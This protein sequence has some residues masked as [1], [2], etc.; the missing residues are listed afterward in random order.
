MVS[1]LRS[2]LF[3]GPLI[4]LLTIGFGTAS[5]VA[6]L[7]DRSGRSPERLARAWARALLRVSGV[8]LRTEGF[9]KIDSRQNYVFVANHRSYMDIPALLASLPVEIRFYA[10]QGLFLIP[11]LGTHLKRAGH[12]PVVRGDARASVKSMTLGARL[13]QERHV[14]MLLFPEGGRSRGSMREFKEGAA[15]IAIKAGVPAVPLGIAGT[16]DVLPMGSNYVR[17]G[18]VILRMGDPIPTAGMKLHDRGQLIALLERQV[19]ELAGESAPQPVETP[20]P[21]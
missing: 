13:I 16:R 21:V 12:L 18:P 20:R 14:S 2:L 15:Y 19:A 11:F 7:F 10:K 9:E 3:T 8:R 5:F 17:G 1:F 4:A 6:T